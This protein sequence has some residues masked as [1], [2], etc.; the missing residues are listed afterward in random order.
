MNYMIRELSEAKE[1]LAKLRRN[2]PGM[3]AALAYSEA[4]VEHPHYVN[5]D[6]LDSNQIAAVRLI[7][8]ES[9]FSDAVDKYEQ[10]LVDM[11]KRS[12]ADIE[13]TI[14]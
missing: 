8:F 1:A 7:A 10:R 12:I 14:E 4:G 2:R 6:Y 11:A 3:V 13:K 9:L 5:F